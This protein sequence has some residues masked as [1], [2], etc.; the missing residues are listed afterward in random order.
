MVATLLATAL[1]VATTM[2]T[3]W[4]GSEAN[5]SRAEASRL[6]AL[7]Q[8]EL[9][10]NPTFALAYALKSLERGD[11]REARLFALRA[12]QRGPTALLA[13]G[14]QEPGLELI[15]AAWN[16]NGEWLALAGYLKVRLLHR[17]GRP[18]LI[19]GYE[20]GGNALA[21]DMP[22]HSGERPPDHGAT[23]RRARLGSGNRQGA[24]PRAQPEVSEAS[25]W[26]RGVLLST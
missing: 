18:A 3:L 15:G 22:L 13:P 26:M 20:T 16:P 2:A 4:R 7:G 1:V 19:V 11:S 9:Q 21:S 6:L 8:V 14:L 17:D 25:L 23:R 10:R 5:L 12:L 24:A